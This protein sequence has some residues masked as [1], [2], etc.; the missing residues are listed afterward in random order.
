MRR[1]ISSLIYGT[2][3]A[4]CVSC[5]PETEGPV[6]DDPPTTPPD[7]PSHF[8][9]STELPRDSSPAIISEVRP[10]AISGGTL[11][12]TRD[13]STAVVADPDRDRILLVTLP[14][15]PAREIPLAPGEDPGR[16]AEDAQGRVHV[17]LRRTGAIAT[18]DVETGE[19]L[20]RREVC[21]APRGIAYDEARDLLHVVCATGELVRLAPSVRRGVLASVHLEP[22]LRDVVVSGD[23]LLVSVFRGATVLV[24]TAD[25]TIVA[26]H[27][28]G[29]RTVAGIN[30][31]LTHVPTT[32]WRMVPMGGGTAAITYQVSQTTPVD[33]ETEPGEPLPYGGF[34][35]T[36]LL[37]RSEVAV[38]GPSGFGTFYGG[39][40][41]FNALPVDLAVNAD[42]TLI[43]QVDPVHALVAERPVDLLFPDDPCNGFISPL[44]GLPLQQP[45]A[46]AYANDMLL[47]QTREPSQLVV[48]QNGAA[49]AM[50]E[51]GGPS[52]N[53][54]GWDLFHGQSS[55]AAATGLACAS[56]HPDGRDA[57]HVWSF[58]DVGPRRTQTLVGTLEG[59]APFHWAGDLATLDALLDEVLA[60]RMGGLGQG[61]ERVNAL[62]TWLATTDV[63]RP[64]RAFVTEVGDA[65]RGRLLFESAETACA[66]CHNGPALTD[67]RTVPVGTGVALQVPSLV[68][69]GMRA[70]YMHDGCASTLHERFEP[71]CGGG[72]SHG[73]TSHLSP[74]DMDDLVAYMM[75][76]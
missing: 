42:Q 29:A 40:F 32:A 69:L 71:A 57:G 6:V 16:A 68:G 27:R 14:Q 39:D 55:A 67:S 25:G 46:A 49:L 23:Q 72:D 38:V 61:P 5:Q 60:R 2:I 1:G 13:A 12:V 3:I 59:T 73:K 41:S 36:T 7:E 63:L 21:A 20:A 64:S 75:T 17:V 37:V 58:T 26:R 30:G 35:C 51:L 48:T 50:I 76:L 9:P 56:C 4:S 44:F 66:T 47:V 11:F 33:V 43:A 24:V 28:P 74:A 70:P 65:E 31:E 54:T 53:D 62:S 22:D 34:D 15:G 18:I 19:I 45:V 8:D 10:P 52:R